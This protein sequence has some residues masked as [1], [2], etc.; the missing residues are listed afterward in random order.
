MQPVIE[1]LQDMINL[2]AL[3][4]LSMGGAGGRGTC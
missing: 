4:S 1:E 3:R 2:Q